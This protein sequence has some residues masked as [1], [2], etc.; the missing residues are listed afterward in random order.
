[1]IFNVAI[2]GGWCDH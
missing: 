2:M 1:M